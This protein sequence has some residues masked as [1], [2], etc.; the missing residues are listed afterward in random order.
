VQSVEF[1]RCATYQKLIL[2]NYLQSTNILQMSLINNSCCAIF[3][4]YNPDANIVENVSSVLAQASEVVIVDNASNIDA[5]EILRDISKDKRVTLILNDRNRG[6]AYALNQG[7]KYA[8]AHEYQWLLTFDQDSLA[9]SD[10]LETLLS[11]YYSTDNQD[12][13]A[14]VAPTYTTRTGTVSFSHTSS[15]N[16]DNQTYSEVETTMTSGNLVA[17]KVF[18]K[19]GFFNEDFFI[20]FVDHEYCLR[21]A[22]SGFRVIESHQALL[23]HELGSLTEHSLLSLRIVTTNHSSIRRYYKYRNMTSILKIYFFDSFP[24]SSQILRAF[25]FEPFKIL[26]FEQDKYSKIQSILKGIYHGTRGI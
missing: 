23:R 26:M 7:V 8:I 19:V 22:K 10:Y 20:D 25:L 17:T 16:S 5:Q 18:D 4:T 12:S 2:G 15:K 24:I 3:V 9:P 11:T 13:I 6:I 14:I 1:S 21:L